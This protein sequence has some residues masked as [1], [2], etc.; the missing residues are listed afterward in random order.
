MN[1]KES[2]QVPQII[3]IHVEFLQPH[4]KE[5]VEFNSKDDFKLFYNFNIDNLSKFIALFHNVDESHLGKITLHLFTELPSSLCIVN[6]N[7][8]I[9]NRNK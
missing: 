7:K 2:I 6:K 4:P 5:L 8:V 3:S 9:L 1:E